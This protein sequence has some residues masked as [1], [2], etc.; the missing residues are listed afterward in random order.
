MS[1]DF[2]IW[3]LHSGAGGQVGGNSEGGLKII[4]ILFTLGLKNVYSSCS[5]Q[6]KVEVHSVLIKTVIQSL[7]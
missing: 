4:K 1:G 6:T 2:L 7:V 3:Q 5:K